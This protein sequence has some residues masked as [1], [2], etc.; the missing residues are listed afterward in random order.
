MNR[1]FEAKKI[2]VENYGR[3]SRPY[4]KIVEQQHQ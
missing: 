2:K 3:P 4:S 1:L